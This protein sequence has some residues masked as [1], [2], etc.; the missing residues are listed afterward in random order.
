MLTRDDRDVLATQC[1]F[2]QKLFSMLR[3]GTLLMIAATA[4]SGCSIDME[5]LMDCKDADG[6]P[7]PES[8]CKKGSPEKSD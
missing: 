7:L 2:S 1:E 5:K 6:N 4:L 3:F 8:V